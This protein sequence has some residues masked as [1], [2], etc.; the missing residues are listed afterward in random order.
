M[1]VASRFTMEAANETKEEGTEVMPIAN[2]ESSETG[3]VE[4]M[5]T[6]KGNLQRNCYGH[7]QIISRGENL[8]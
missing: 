2:P 6:S 5:K 4:A 7:D 1:S 8:P 3:G